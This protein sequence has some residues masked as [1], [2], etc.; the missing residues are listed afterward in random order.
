MSLTIVPMT[1]LPRERLVL[2][3]QRLIEADSRD[4]EKG[5]SVESVGN[6]WLR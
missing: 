4:E 5:S 2:A 3:R 1:P 6:V